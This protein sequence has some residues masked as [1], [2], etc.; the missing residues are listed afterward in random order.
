MQVSFLFVGCCWGVR[1][2]VAVWFACCPRVVFETFGGFMTATLRADL[3]VFECRSL[4]R[5]FEKMHH[6]QTNNV[7]S[8]AWF[9]QAPHGGVLRPGAGAGQGRGFRIRHAV[10]AVGEGG[11]RFQVYVRKGEPC[12]SLS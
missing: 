2:V 6:Q 8:N 4:R 12:S 9:S 5:P 3:M 10:G 11:Q 7:R 1:A